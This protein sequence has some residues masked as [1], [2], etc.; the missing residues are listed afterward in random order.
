MRPSFSST[1]THHSRLKPSHAKPSTPCHQYGIS[2]RTPTVSYC[3]H[4]D[5]AICH[6]SDLSKPTL[7][8]SSRPI[9]SNERS[10]SGTAPPNPSRPQEVHGNGLHSSEAVPTQK[11][12]NGFQS[13][14][15]IPIHSSE[16]S[17]SVT[18]P[19]N[20]S[21][22]TQM[23]G[24]GFPS[25]AAIPIP[26]HKVCSSVRCDEVSCLSSTSIDEWRAV[27]SAGE[28]RAV[29][30]ATTVSMVP[31]SLDS[32]DGVSSSWHAVQRQAGNAASAHVGDSWHAVQRLAA[33]AMCGLVVQRQAGNAASAHVGDSWHAVQRLAATAM[34]G[35][36]V[37][38]QAGNA[39]SAHVGDSWHAVQRLA[40][41]AMCGLVVQRQAGNAA[42]AHVGDSWH[43]V[44]RLAATAMCGLVVQA[45]LLLVPLSVPPP[46]HAHIPLTLPNAEKRSE[47]APD[48]VRGNF[49]GD[50]L[51]LSYRQPSA[52]PQNQRSTA[53]RANEALSL[54]KNAWAQSDAE[55]YDE[56]LSSF[57]AVTQWVGTVGV[58]G[59]GFGLAGGVQEVQV[60]TVCV[61]G[62][63]FGLAV[64]V[65]EVH[66][67]TVGV[68]GFGFGLAVGVQEVHVGA[69]G[70]GGSGFGVVVEVQEVQE[71]AASQEF[72]KRYANPEFARLVK[73]WPEKLVNAKR[74]AR[75]NKSLGAA[76]EAPPPSLGTAPEWKPSLLTISRT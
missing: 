75:R 10:A 57:T 45:A 70:L 29:Q 49:L 23:Q 62:F 22:P 5:T 74:H 28:W 17:A 52:T 53:T 72:D 67:G 35:L 55:R 73:H 16:R 40:A 51:R 15:A 20:P 54:L 46:A 33:T 1:L 69:D 36:V 63:G 48:T 8:P 3:H 39:A 34:C 44:Q 7:G 30:S 61:V 64:G 9:H 41:T 66:V 68:V 24:N 50:D 25:V 47:P 4:S 31:F 13:V 42:S 6:P 21:I 27:Q 60:G 11:Q 58:V 2:E 59:F 18:A 71:W 37:Q 76:P 19:S 26:K 56:A 38:R 43:A 32:L 12:G 14:A 65:Q